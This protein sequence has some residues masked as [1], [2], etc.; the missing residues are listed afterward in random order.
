MVVFLIIIVL[1]GVIIL[2][3]VDKKKESASKI[4]NIQNKPTDIINTTVNNDGKITKS[5]A[6]NVVNQHSVD[7]KSFSNIN[8]AV[9]LW[10]FNI[11]PNKFENEL[12]LILVKKDSFIWIRLP[13]GAVSNP[14]RKFRFRE[15]KG[16]IEIKIS[17]KPGYNHLRD[18]SSGGIGF[19]FE[20]YVQ[21]EFKL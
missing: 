12:H 15:D 13:E 4:K 3:I 5:K 14:E 11:S 8:K 2:L 9:S 18:E 17:P 6:V 1:L 7:C 19:G 10:W 20:Q 21:K 16:L